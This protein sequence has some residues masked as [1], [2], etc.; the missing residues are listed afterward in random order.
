MSSESPPRDWSREQ[1]VAW[2]GQIPNLVQAT[3]FVS[4]KFADVT[5]TELL[6]F[7]R[8]DVKDLG[9]TRPGTVV[10]LVDAIQKLR[11]DDA[12][13]STTFIE[14]SEYCFG[15]IIDHLRLR[16]KSKISGVPELAPPKVREVE[17]TRY[18][19]IVDFYFPGEEAA[20][21]FLGA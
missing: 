12:E 16:T 13:S 3:D 2:V 20:A 18:K 7:G 1:V 9:I 15:K 10:V 21:E 19:R 6:L 11:E 8:E 5:G 14:H 17:R 4:S